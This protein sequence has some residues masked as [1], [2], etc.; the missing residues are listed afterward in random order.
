MDLA[1]RQRP[2]VATEQWR[3]PAYDAAAAPTPQHTPERP[4]WD[5][6]VCKHG[7]PCLE[8]RRSLLTEYSGPSLSLFVAMGARLVDMVAD[9]PEVAGGVLYERALGWVRDVDHER[10]A[11]ATARPSLSIG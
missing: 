8:A 10:R 11:A 1:E 5:C 9:R 7:W 6:R 2:A 4:S 3:A